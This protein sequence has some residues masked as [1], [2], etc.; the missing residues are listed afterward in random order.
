MGGA[1]YFSFEPADPG[2]SP[3]LGIPIWNRQSQDSSSQTMTCQP[4]RR[5]RKEAL[6][7]RH[8][9]RSFLS[10]LQY[11]HAWP[12]RTM[13]SPF[14]KISNRC[15]Y[16][17]GPFSIRG[18][19]LPTQIPQL[20]I[21]SRATPVVGIPPFGAVIISLRGNGV[22]RC[23]QQLA[24]SVGRH[25]LVARGYRHRCAGAMLVSD[26]FCLRSHPHF[27]KQRLRSI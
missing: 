25:S 10:V 12:R 3:P 21:Q 23:I 15:I 8:S 5:F 6:W 20:T 14:R 24:R 16:L 18:S 19:S 1:T 9:A 13:R 7:V 17:T 27:G 4:F 11:C 2:G 22:N 26:K